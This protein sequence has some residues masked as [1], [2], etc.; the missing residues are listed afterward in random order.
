MTEPIGTR[1]WVKRTVVNLERI[2]QQA[3]AEF[4]TNGI[5]SVY[6]VTQLVNSFLGIIVRTFENDGGSKDKEGSL[7]TRVPLGQLNIMKEHLHD[8]ANG[9]WI[10]YPDLMNTFDDCFHGDET[11]DNF[12]ILIK[13]LRNSVSHADI[14]PLVENTEAGPEGRNVDYIRFSD[15]KDAKNPNFGTFS[16]TINVQ[17]IREFLRAFCNNV[18]GIKYSIHEG[19]E[20]ISKS[21]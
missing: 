18:W 8:A 17:T 16:A 14:Q 6:E 7:I 19:L 15:M 4:R 5:M 11:A 3:V 13:R 9:E 21:I 20:D 10:P 2:E 1:D 12:R